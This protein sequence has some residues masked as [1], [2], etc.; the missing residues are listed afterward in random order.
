MN[1]NTLRYSNFDND[2]FDTDAIQAYVDQLIGIDG[3]DAVIASIDGRW[4]TLTADAEQTVRDQFAS[5]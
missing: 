3:E 5:L 4:A 2:E 1:T